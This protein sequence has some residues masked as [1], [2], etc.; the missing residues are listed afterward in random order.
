MFSKR[1]ASSDT[2]GLDPIATR[3]MAEMLFSD[4]VKLYQAET[5]AKKLSWDSDDSK[6]RLYLLPYFGSK[7]LGAITRINI[8]RYHTQLTEKLSAASANRHISLLKAILT[9]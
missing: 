6:F 8:E 2:K 3:K 1:N 4:L 5:K 9:F 7:Q